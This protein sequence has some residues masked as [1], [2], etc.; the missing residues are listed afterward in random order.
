MLVAGGGESKSVRLRG[1]VGRKV[2]D[3]S[4]AEQLVASSCH[5]SNDYTSRIDIHQRPRRRT[6]V[7][8]PAR[9]RKCLVPHHRDRDRCRTNAAT[10]NKQMQT[11]YLDGRSAPYLFE[12][13]SERSRGP[14]DVLEKL[15]KY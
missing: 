3:T 13:P 9:T 7:A 4:A 6:N 12:S 14:Y 1:T 10:W 15:S 8:A 5:I 2:E 11:R